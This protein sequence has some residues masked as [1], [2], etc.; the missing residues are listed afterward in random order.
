MR[1][2]YCRIIFLCSLAKW[3]EDNCA[4]IKSCEIKFNFVGRYNNK[5]T[6]L[7]ETDILQ[8][9]RDGDRLPFIEVDVCSLVVSIG[10]FPSPSDFYNRL[11]IRYRYDGDKNSF[12]FF[13]HSIDSSNP[14]LSNSYQIEWQ[15]LLTLAD[16]DDFDHILIKQHGMKEQF[17]FGKKYY[18]DE[19]LL[20]N[21]SDFITKI[22]VNHIRILI[23]EF[24]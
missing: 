16:E 6:D 8:C 4:H 17:D 20:K 22:F 9:L 18:F 2:N 13:L 12:L 15:E 14:Y 10:V 23:S 1:E 21:M 5:Y 11:K 3:I 7:K 24:N 19:T